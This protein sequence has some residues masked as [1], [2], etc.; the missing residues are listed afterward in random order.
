M[1]RDDQGRVCS[2]P[3]AWT[4]VAAPDAYVVLS[5]GRS[6][7]QPGDLVALAARVRLL[8]RTSGVPTEKEKATGGVR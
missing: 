3:A 8:V 4:S 2:L 5:A 7:F 1:Y 6:L